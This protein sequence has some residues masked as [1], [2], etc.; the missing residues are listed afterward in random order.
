MGRY[1]NVDDDDVGSEL[2]S[3]DG[4]AV[5][6]HVEGRHYGGGDGTGGTGGTG[7]DDEEFVGV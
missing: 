4:V 1:G 3:V 5:G 7:E 6:T 2:G